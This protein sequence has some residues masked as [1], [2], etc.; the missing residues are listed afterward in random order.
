[1]PLESNDAL[2][3][4][5]VNLR[6][7]ANVSRCMMIGLTVPVRK[8]DDEGNETSDPVRGRP[9]IKIG[10]SWRPLQTPKPDD[11]SIKWTFGMI[12]TGADIVAVNAGFA[13]PRVAL[14]IP[15]KYWEA[16]TALGSG[17]IPIYDGHLVVTNGARCIVIETEFAA[18]NVGQGHQVVL[19]RHF[20]RFVTYTHNCSYGIEK[21]TIG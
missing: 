5:Q 2:N 13:N 8:L 4:L 11:P 15:K 3:G 9:C 14:K 6:A 18:A 16:H 20:L 12:D 19:G 1:M 21:L 7:E 10:F 17:R